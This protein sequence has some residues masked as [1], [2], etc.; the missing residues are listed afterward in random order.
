M[1]IIQA[2][3][4]ERFFKP[5]FKNLE[6]WHAWTVFLSAL[7]ALPITGCKDR[8]LFLKCTQRKRTPQEPAREAYVLAGRRSGKSFIS[9]VIAVYLAC[10]KDWT[11]NLSP[12]ERGWIF[13]V[14]NDK[15]QAKIIKDYVSGILNSKPTFRKMITQERQWEIELENRISIGVKT[16]DF[17]TLRGYTVLAAICEEIAFWRDENSANP[18]QEIITALKPSLATIPESLLIGIST[19]Y[20]QSG[21]LYEQWKKGFGKHL[22]GRLIWQAPTLLMN[23]T[24]PAQTVKDALNEDRSS[25]LSE[26]SAEFRKDIESFLPLEL[27][28]AATVKNCF[29]LPSIPNIRYF[30]FCDPSGGRRDSMTLGIAHKD[31]DTGKII[32]DCLQEARPPFEPDSIVRQFSTILKRYGVY[33]IESDRYA[34]EWVSSAFRS[35]GIMVSPSQMTASE[36][37]LNF[38]PLM[39]NHSI[40]LLD[41]KRLA[42][43]LRGLERKTRTG[44]KDLVS[45]YHGGFDDLANA[46][47]GAIV[48]CW[49]ETNLEPLPL[50]SFGYSYEALTLEEKLER[51]ALEMLRDH[52]TKEEKKALWPR[53]ERLGKYLDDEGNVIEDDEELRGPGSGH[54]FEDERTLLKELEREQHEDRKAFLRDRKKRK[55]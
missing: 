37:Y 25:A 35:Q 50:P 47:T 40:E 29:E 23:P 28:E 27:I 14:A 22:R 8:R 48:K 24:I 38:L 45:H 17:R 19:P 49:T 30:G 10:F 43:Q 3:L 1:N 11:P 36:L 42:S 54:E 51:D 7:F 55:L 12:G 53:D 21:Y 39:S 32:L 34:G 16:C 44:G 4:D 5:L 52:K 20:S 46:S 15:S 18:A 2:M 9:S 6:T 33:Q 26:Y 13:I 41:S 31:K